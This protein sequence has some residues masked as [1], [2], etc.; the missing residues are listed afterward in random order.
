[1]SLLTL[2]NESRTDIVSQSGILSRT[3]ITVE[4][5]YPTMLNLERAKQTDAETELDKLQRWI[6][7]FPL[8]TH[9]FQSRNQTIPRWF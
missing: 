5:F 2:N 9:T 3:T 7:T 8:R 6:H 4:I 1:M